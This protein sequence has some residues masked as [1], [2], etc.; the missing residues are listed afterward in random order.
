MTPSEPT[1][2]ERAERFADEHAYSTDCMADERKVALHAYEVG[3]EDAIAAAAQV[4]DEEIRQLL[5]L[6]RGGTMMSPNPGGLTENG[7]GQ[8]AAWKEAARRIRALGG[9]DEGE[10]NQ[11]KGVRG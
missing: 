7:K 2:K 5:M 4:A 10:D 9:S 1:A 8:L 6:S 3:W 11:G